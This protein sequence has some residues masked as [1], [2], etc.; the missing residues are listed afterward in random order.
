MIEHVVG[1]CSRRRFVVVAVAVLIAAVA[2][3]YVARHFAI[4]TDTAKLIAADAP[5]RQSELAFD[6]AFPHRGD[7]IAIVVDGA[8]PELAERA[9]AELTRR[10]AGTRGLFRA[11]WRPDGG[12]FFDRN[13]LLFQSTGELMRTT[14][15]LIEAQPLLGSLAH[16]PSLRGL[17]DAIALVV[18]G[19]SH[20]QG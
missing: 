19:A 20:D 10:I 4:D 13:G 11:V 18:V 12:P 17:M 1:A 6:A 15:R 9:T 7:L 5:W 2:S 8:T 3:T 14:Q 16:D